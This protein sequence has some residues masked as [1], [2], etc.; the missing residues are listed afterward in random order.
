[1]ATDANNLGRMEINELINYL[2]EIKAELK[3][4]NEV[5]GWSECCVDIICSTD[6]EKT[7]KKVEVV[8]P[9]DTSKIMT[10]WV[11]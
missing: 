9:V 6:E 1:M 3:L 7:G 10:L 2:S 5:L 11:K 8:D 4:N